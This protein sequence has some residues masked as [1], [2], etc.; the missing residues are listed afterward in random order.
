MNELP[1]IFCNIRT[2]MKPK[3]KATNCYISEH[4]KWRICNDFESYSSP[5][6]LANVKGIG[7]LRLWQKQTHDANFGVL[8]IFYFHRAK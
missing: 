7:S 1:G 5:C 8:S 6:C 2:S 4:K 3:T